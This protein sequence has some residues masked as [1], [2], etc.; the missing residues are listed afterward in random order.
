[1]L[2]VS[3]LRGFS[4][5]PHA[6][7]FG[8]EG[9]CFEVELVLLFFQRKNWKTKRS[10]LRTRTGEAQQLLSMEILKFDACWPTR[11]TFPRKKNCQSTLNFLKIWAHLR[12]FSC[13]IILAHQ[14]AWQSST[15]NEMVSLMLLLFAASLTSSKQLVFSAFYHGLRSVAHSNVLNSTQHTLGSRS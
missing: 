4:S 14:I 8:W 15:E 12:N 9:C 6:K 3:D 13:L 2:F 5:P 11:W 1:M 10:Q 7:L